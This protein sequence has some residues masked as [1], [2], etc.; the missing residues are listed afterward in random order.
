MTLGMSPAGDRV[1]AGI[2]AFGRDGD[3]EAGLAGGAGVG[4]RADGAQA[5]GVGEFEDGNQDLLSGAGV[6]CTARQLANLTISLRL[7][8][9]AEI[10]PQLLQTKGEI[11][12]FNPEE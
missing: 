1:I 6:G 12:E 4:G 5:T 9:I 7:E 2:F 10:G 8:I 11:A 3:I